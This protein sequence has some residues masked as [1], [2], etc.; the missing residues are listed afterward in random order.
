MTRRFLLSLLVLL[1]LTGH[2]EGFSPPERRRLQFQTA[3]GIVFRA[4]VAT[5]HEGGEATVIIGHSWESL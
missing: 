5:D 1:L 4:D 3:S 2:S